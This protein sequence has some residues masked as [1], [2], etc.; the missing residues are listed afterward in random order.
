MNHITTIRLIITSFLFAPALL[1]QPELSTG[2]GQPI[3]YDDNRGALV[4]TGDAQLRD[5]PFLVRA[6]EIG[7]YQQEQR[8]EATGNVELTRSGVRLLTDDVEYGIEA[9]AFSGTAFKAGRYP[10]F[11]EGERFEGDHEQ[12]TFYDS[13]AYFGEPADFG[14]SMKADSITI[15]EPNQ[16][17]ARDAIFRLGNIPFLKLPQYSQRAGDFPVR[18]DGRA[19]YRGNL[20]AYLANEFTVL[21]APHTFVGA[22]LDGYTKRGVLI[23]PA[24]NYERDQ[25]NEWLKSRF[26]AGYI[27]D[28]GDTGFDLNGDPIDKDR[29]FIEWRHNQHWDDAFTLNAVVSLWSDS[30]VMRDFRP[31]YFDN[32]QKPDNW[33]EASWDVGAFQFS[34]FTRFRPNDFQIIRQRIPELRMDLMPSPIPRLGIYQS[35][36]V[37]LAILQESVPDSF[38]VLPVF[39]PIQPVNQ[40]TQKVDAHYTWIRPIKVTRGVTFTPRAGTRFIHYWKTLDDRGT[41]DR[42]F[43]ELGFD[44][45]ALAHATWDYKNPMWK[46]DGLR[47]IVRSVVQYRYTP[48]IDSDNNIPV[49]IDRP[50]ISFNRLPINLNTQ[51]NFDSYLPAEDRNLFRLGF[52]N[53]WQTRHEEWGSRDLVRL[54]VYQDVLLDPGINQQ[55]LDSF[56]TELS[57]TPASWLEVGMF[58]RSQMEN[59]D[60]SEFNTRIR[61]RDGNIWSLGLTTQFVDQ[62]VE[63]YLLEYQYQVLRNFGIECYVRWDPNFGALTDQYYAISQRIGNIMLARYG[64]RVRDG[65]V[66]EDDFSFSVQ[67]TFIDF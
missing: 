21:V 64:I 31:G 20:G 12:I 23:G 34:A 35:G 42:W 52:E 38:L 30:E 44:L 51:R 28:T 63:Q 49:A 50:I 6:E 46:I 65:A 59:F 24:F 61:I 56:W 5:G 40:D 3:E 36:A 10:L 26:S 29:G 15:R 14:F 13:T 39:P 17:S 43:G 33:A 32:N 8:V 58:A 54:N 57:A 22:N 11:L 62:K 4:A 53:I 19:G 48:V 55:T 7:F 1:A 41:H 45:E 60:V 67:V 18:Y 16:V 25:G 27:H 37:S 9:K 2:P 66:R 47:H